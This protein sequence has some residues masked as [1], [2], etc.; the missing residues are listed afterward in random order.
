MK[1]ETCSRQGQES[2]PKS[3]GDMQSFTTHPTFRIDAAIFSSQTL[4]AMWSTVPL[5]L[6]FEF[7]HHRVCL[8]RDRLPFKARSSICGNK[9]ASL[10][11]TSLSHN[12]SRFLYSEND[13]CFPREESSKETKAYIDYGSPFAAKLIE[14]ACIYEAPFLIFLPKFQLLFRNVCTLESNKYKV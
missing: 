7:S 6:E 1:T 13:S 2:P 14:L 5:K 3:I 4:Y 8:S 9:I 11:V 10:S 12:P